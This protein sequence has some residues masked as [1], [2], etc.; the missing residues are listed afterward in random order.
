MKNKTKDNIKG[1]ELIWEMSEDDLINDKQ[2]KIVFTLTIHIYLIRNFEIGFHLW[3]I[4]YFECDY[5]KIELTLKK[6]YID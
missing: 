1:F 4:K 5:L 6:I 2:E 3:K